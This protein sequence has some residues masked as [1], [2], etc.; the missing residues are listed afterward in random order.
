MTF[1]KFKADGHITCFSSN[2]FPPFRNSPVRRR[3]RSSADRDVGISPGSAPT[4]SLR[5]RGPCW[6][7]SSPGRP[8][9]LLRPALRDH[10]LRRRGQRPLPCPTP[11]RGPALYPIQ[12]GGARGGRPSGRPCGRATLPGAGGSARDLR[13]LRTAHAPPRSPGSARPPRVRTRGGRGFLG[14]RFEASG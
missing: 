11:V 3:E 4:C 5:S 13:G 12:T 8:Q 7:A 9:H 2:V 1:P 10:V 14:V 6:G